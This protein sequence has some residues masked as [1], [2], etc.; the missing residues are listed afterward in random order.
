MIHST[1]NQEDTQVI[2]DASNI[3]IKPRV[4]KDLK[5][6]HRCVFLLAWLEK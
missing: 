4:H 2:S 5:E 1:T 6:V 3:K